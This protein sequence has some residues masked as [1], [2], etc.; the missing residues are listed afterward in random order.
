MN[1]VQTVNVV[2]FW[3][4][5]ALVWYAYVGYPLLIWFL[6]RYFG[7][8]AE[9]PAANADDLPSL[10]LLIA[11]YNEE[12]VIEERIQN[13]LEMDYPADRLEIVVA[14]DGST[15]DTPE[16]VRRYAGAGV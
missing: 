4:C 7:R 5:T 6:A 9:A 14:S 13:A 2:V 15:D 1:S 12:D 3:V 8:R 16:I 10:S 11:A